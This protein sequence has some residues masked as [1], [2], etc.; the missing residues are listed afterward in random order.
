METNTSEV[1]Q[2]IPINLI[3]VPSYGRIHSAEQLE[4]LSADMAANGLIQSIVVV[5]DG[6][7]YRVVVGKGR[8]E[9]AKKLDWQTIQAQVR[10]ELTQVQKFTL[11][12]SENT[13]REDVS[14]FYTAFLYRMILEAGNLT[15]DELAL[16]FRKDRSLITRYMRLSKVPPEVWQENQSFLTSLRPCLEIAKVENIDVQKKLVEACV[17]EGL[18]GPGLKKL[19]K[20]LTGDSEPK[21]A[22]TEETADSSEAFRFMWKGNSLKIQG[23]PFTP[24]TELISSY[25]TELEQAYD[26]FMDKEK[27]KS[28]PTP[29]AA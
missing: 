4:S 21:E 13:E 15:Q 1:T 23:R 7:R 28:T 3:D 18:D 19:A 26:R 20:T 14:P 16:K 10:E 17:K 6:E 2:L 22:K 11:V 5:K 24:H 9:A 29:A 8:L 27:S 25:L 12:A